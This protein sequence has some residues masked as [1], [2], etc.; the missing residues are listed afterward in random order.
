MKLTQLLKEIKINK[1]ISKKEVLDTFIDKDYC[2]LLGDLNNFSTLDEF[3]NEK[4]M[5][6]VKAYV[7]DC[8]GYEDD[9]D[10]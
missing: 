10:V 1:P 2:F 7:I 6:D 8:Y 4:E 5:D 3:L 9:D